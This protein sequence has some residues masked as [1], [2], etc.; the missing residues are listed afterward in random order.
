[1]ELRVSDKNIVVGGGIGL[2]GMLFILL[3]V[4]KLTG[5]IQTSWLWVVAS[6]FIGPAI[7]IGMFLLVGLFILVALSVAAIIH[8]FD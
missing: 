7:S 8:L 4:L 5:T 2:G 3:L 6:L 1:M